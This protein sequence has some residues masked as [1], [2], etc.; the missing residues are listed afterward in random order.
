VH[1]RPAN[2]GLDKGW[3]NAACDPV[4]GHV[5]YFGG[6]HSTYQVNDVAVYA[7]GA[8]AWAPAAGDFNSFVTPQ[9]WEGSTLGF[10]GGP[11]CGHQ[12]NA[13]QSFD[14]RMYVLVGTEERTAL[15]SI[16]S[17]WNYVFH[18]DKDCVRFYDLDRGGIWR[19]MRISHIERPDNVPNHPNVHMVDP[20]GR[21]INLIRQPDPSHAGRIYRYVY[22]G[23]IDKFFTSIYDMQE[24]KLLVREVPKPYPESA[25]NESRP[26]CYLAGQGKVFYMSAKP[27][28][29]AAA[30]A[31]KKPM[32]QVT[33]LY[34][35]KENK[36]TELRP[37]HTPPLGGVQVVEY[38]ESHKCVL[39][40]IGGRQWVYSF[41]KND[42]AELSLA[43]EGGKMGFQGPYGQMVWVARYGVFVNLNGSTWIMRPDF[44]RIFKDANA[45]PSSGL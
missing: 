25:E 32:K 42:W 9:G 15:G 30:D 36:F 12:R 2:D 35:T 37:A 6:G 17:T 26:Y 24:D 10:R 33:Y 40:V 5:Y 43:A 21:I 23:R 20:D 14:G 27:D 34:D 7:V 31:A 29:G 4:R 13:Y 28:D 18:A 41:E 16:G 11:A 38:A 22:S 8:N 1:V 44:A 3:G 45:H 19:E 39:A